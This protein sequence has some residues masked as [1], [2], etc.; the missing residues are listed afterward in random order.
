MKLLVSRNP[1]ESSEDYIFQEDY[2]V[3]I[4]S[5]Y[6]KLYP[7]SFEYWTLL[8]P[9]V[10]GPRPAELDSKASPVAVLLENEN[11]FYYGQTSLA[12]PTKPHGKGIYIN[13]KINLFREG[14]WMNG[15]LHCRGR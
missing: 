7:A 14:W 13:K 4:F 9:F 11:F 10:W 12:D 5:G 1:K 6:K 3:D 8:D 2:L 15:K